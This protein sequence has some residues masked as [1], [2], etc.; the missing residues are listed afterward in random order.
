MGKKIEV[1][2]NLVKIEKVEVI[3]KKI[4]AGS[5]VFE[6]KNPFPGYYHETPGSAKE[7]YMYI[8]LAKHHT[9]EEILRATQK[10]ELDFKGSFDAGKGFLTIVNE[11]YY[12]LRLRHFGDYD[13]I[14]KIQEA[15]ANVGI[16]LLTNSKKQGIYDANIRIV[17]FLSLEDAGDGVYLDLKDEH[18]GF[19]T[20]PKYL[21]W[22]EFYNVTMQVRYNWSGSEFDAAYGSFQH[23]GKLHEMIRIYSHKMSPEYLKEIRKVYLEKIK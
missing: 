12:V 10:I 20:I 15:Y 14:V 22:D 6:S 11:L 7:A 13:M 3:K 1:F 23:N 9:L 19:I 2:S 5:L 4:V 21:S 17:K 18:I 16:D 8:A